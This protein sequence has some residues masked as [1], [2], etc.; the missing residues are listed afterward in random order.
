MGKQQYCH[1]LSLELAEGWGSPLPSPGGFS[2][3]D[4]RRYNRTASAL[5]DPRSAQLYDPKSLC[6]LTQVFSHRMDFAKDFAVP[7]ECFR[8]PLPL[9][10]PCTQPGKQ[11]LDHGA[12]N[13]VQNPMGTLL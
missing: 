1:R 4:N 9:W 11:D 2:H 10:Y 13:E 7:F 5:D 6:G 8:Y 12:N 3:R